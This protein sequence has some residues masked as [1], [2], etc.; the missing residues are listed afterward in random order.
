MRWFVR[1]YRFRTVVVAAAML[2]AMVT[3]RPVPAN[4]AGRIDDVTHT[5]HNL[6]ITGPGP[7][8]ATSESRICV[9]CH[10]PHAAEKIPAAPLWNRKLSGAT[11]VPYSSGSMKAVV[12]QPG[13]SSRLCLSCHD[14]TLALGTVHVLNTREN[15]TIGL[16]GTGTGGTMPT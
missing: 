11:Y 9:F 8:T 7:V 15:V 4:L 12:G 14:G 2:A 5:V 6:S 16:T 3:A 13:G 10:T 1:H